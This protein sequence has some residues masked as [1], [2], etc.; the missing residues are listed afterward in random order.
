MYDFDSKLG[1]NIVVCDDL[2]F[3]A[4]DVFGGLI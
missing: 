3:S 2:A 4:L 1:A